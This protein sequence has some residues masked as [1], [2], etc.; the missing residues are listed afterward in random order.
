M[1]IEIWNG[2]AWEAA[3]PGKGPLDGYELEDS[4]YRFIIDIGG[5]SVPEAVKEAYKRL[6]SYM[7]ETGRKAGVSSYSAD[8]GVLKIAYTQSPSWMAKAM[9]NS[10]AADLL[11]PY[12][13]S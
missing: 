13:R 5:G 9:Q 6:S 1:S 11:R 10:G 3:T 7:A 12:R 8:L 2:T 4:K